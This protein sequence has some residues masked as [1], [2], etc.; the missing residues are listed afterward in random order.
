VAPDS[1][2]AAAS[3]TVLGFRDRPPRRVDGRSFLSPAVRSLLAER[4]VD[5]EEIRGTGEGGRV[6]RADVLAYVDAREA[7]GE[8][9]DAGAPAGEAEARAEK[10]EIV[11]FSPLRRRTAEHMVR[12]KATAAHAAVV[13]E[14][15]YESVARI[16]R[17]LGAVWREQEGFGLTY[18]PFVARAVVDAIAAFPRV[19]ASIR[20][21]DQLVVFRE[22]HLG[23]AV[24][25]DH[26]GLIVPV[27]RNARAKRLRAIAAE[28]TDLASRARAKQL[29]P[30]D[31]GG[32]TFTITN[33]GPYGTLVSVPIINQPQVAILATDRIT[34]RPVVVETD[35]GDSVA[36]RAVGRLTLSFDHRAFDGAY[37]AAFLARVR[38]VIETRPWDVEL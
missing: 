15:D 29:S 26:E 38:N 24:D 36:V 30:D 10:A 35:G 19:N 21:G 23:V 13:V 25:L 12:S 22:V 20:D 28:I 18:L 33:P 5:P 9:R 6:T 27:V 7:R 3:P 11:P 4:D 17:R 1:P 37:A 14:V 32:G 2:T 34:P 31:V 8:L 16:R